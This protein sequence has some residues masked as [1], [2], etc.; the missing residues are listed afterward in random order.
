[1]STNNGRRFFNN[2]LLTWSPIQRIRNTAERLF[3]APAPA[4]KQQSKC[5]ADFVY[6]ESYFTT[7]APV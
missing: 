5:L 4:S 2:Y 6:L 1:M 3:E 7:F